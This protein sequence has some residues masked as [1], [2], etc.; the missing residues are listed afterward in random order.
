MGP[1]WLKLAGLCLLLL[2]SACGEAPR[3]QEGEIAPRITSYNVCY[4]KLLRAL[5]QPGGLATG[6]E[7][8]QQA[9]T[10]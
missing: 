1:W 10:G 2:L 8:Q 4:T 3:L 6:A 7:E 5:M 9:E